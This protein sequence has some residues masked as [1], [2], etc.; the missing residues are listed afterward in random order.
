MQS[1][2]VIEAEVGVPV[3]VCPST[4][5]TLLFAFHPHMPYALTNLQT[6]IAFFYGNN[7]PLN[8]SCQF[9]AACSFHPFI[10]AN[11][12]LATYMTYG[13]SILHRA[14]DVSITF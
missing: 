10:C 9:F 1:V 4:L 14:P 5:L 6:V 8:L 2:D 7:V 11:L 3:E 12:N 13:R